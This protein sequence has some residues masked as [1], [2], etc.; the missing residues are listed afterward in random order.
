MDLLTIFSG[1][2]ENVLEA[3]PGDAAKLLVQ[4]VLARRR[5][6]AFEILLQE[7]RRGGG[8]LAPSDDAIAAVLRYQRAADEGAARRNLRLLAMV[9]AGKARIGDLKADE[10][11]YV[12]DMLASLRREEIILLATMQRIRR[13]WL[14][15]EGGPSPMQQWA[16]TEEALIPRLFPDK[17][18]MRAVVTACLRTGLLSDDNTMDNSGWYETT[19]YMDELEAM[20]PFE[21][22][23]EE[24]EPLPR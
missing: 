20:A 18:A 7:L 2:A 3:I 17:Q 23:L 4:G 8:P 15:K 1:M 16:I 13:A 11:L 12:A 21:A 24:D 5:N 19:R 22:A 9:I 6:A 10:F 14:G